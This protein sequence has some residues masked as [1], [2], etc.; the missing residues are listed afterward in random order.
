MRSRPHSH[1]LTRGSA[2]HMDS[3]KHHKL[4]PIITSTRRHW[5]IGRN[6]SE[7]QIKA[8]KYELSRLGQAIAESE[9]PYLLGTDVSLVSAADS[10]KCS[11]T[12]FSLSNGLLDCS[13]YGHQ[14]IQMRNG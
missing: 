3:A 6:P 2:C 5:G 13:N 8:F 4:T 11:Y 12:L 9:G 7:R 14:F 10:A 1:K